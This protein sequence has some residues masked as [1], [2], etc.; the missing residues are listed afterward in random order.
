MSEEPDN[1]LDDLNELDDL[2]DDELDDAAGDD[3]EDDDDDDFEC[4]DNCQS[5]EEPD[6]LYEIAEQSGWYCDDCISSLNWTAREP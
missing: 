1:L 4:C 3:E 5:K 6:N 2:D